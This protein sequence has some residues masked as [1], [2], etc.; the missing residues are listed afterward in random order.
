V[1][2]AI[3]MAEKSKFAAIHRHGGAPDVHPGLL[4]SMLFGG[5]DAVA[6]IKPLRTPGRSV[7]QQTLD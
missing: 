4:F 2:K 5:D 7:R 1:G 3:E 6:V